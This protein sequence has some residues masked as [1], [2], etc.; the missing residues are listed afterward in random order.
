MSNVVFVEVLAIIGCLEPELS[1]GFALG[2]WSH[3]AVHADEACQPYTVEAFGVEDSRGVADT[4][5]D[6]GGEIKG[7]DSRLRGETQEAFANTLNEA[8]S[9]F[10]L[11]SLER[12]P[13]KTS[14][15]ACQTSSESI[16]ARGNSIKRMFWPISALRH[17]PLVLE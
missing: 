12:M 10:L 4:F 9:T 7:P 17:S 8:V 14:N 1:Q 6:V 2:V 16:A 5:G 3:D 13:C 15:T 11:S